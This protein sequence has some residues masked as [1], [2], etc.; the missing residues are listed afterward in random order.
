MEETAGSP[1]GLR[2]LKGGT[3]VPTKGLLTLI[4]DE[5]IADSIKTTNIGHQGTR[6]DSIL[7]YLCYRLGGHK[8]G[9]D[10]VS[11]AYYVGTE[12]FFTI[13]CRH[14]FIDGNKR[15]AYAS[16]TL[17]VFANL[18]EA[19]GEGKAIELA[20]EEDTGKTIETIARWGEGSDSSSLRELLYNEGMLG[21]KK[22]E[23]KEEDVKRFINKF[24]RNTIRVQEED[25][26]G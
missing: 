17:A 2:R 18:S 7:E 4:H 8:Y 10:A 26:H 5:V 21:K 25:S 11:N 15:T 22:R 3:L 16:A 13:A 9:E 14:P 23:M 12:T 24:L 1:S 19:L 6:D 20:E